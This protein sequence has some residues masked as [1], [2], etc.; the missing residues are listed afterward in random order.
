MSRQI[1]TVPSRPYSVTQLT[2]SA[3]LA[4]ALKIHW[5]EYLMEAAELGVLMFCIC[6]FG[7]MLYNRASAPVCYERLNSLIV[8]P[9]QIDV[10]RFLL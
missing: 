5:R 2:P 8:L 1:L 6:I 7:T 3:S 4:Q 9:L 10:G